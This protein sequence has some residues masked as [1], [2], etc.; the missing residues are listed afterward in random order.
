MSF[1]RLGAAIAVAVAWAPLGAP[2]NNAASAFMASL[3]VSTATGTVPGR[4][5]DR[6]SARAAVLAGNY[7]S[8]LHHQ[9]RERCPS[10]CGDVGADTSDWPVYG[11]LEGLSRAC[12]QTMLLDFALYNLVN[13]PKAKVAISA[14]T[15]DLQLSSS[16]SAAS[17]AGSVTSTCVPEGVQRTKA[18]STLQLLS[19]GNSSPSHLAD[20]TAALDQLRAF[21]SIPDTGCNETIKYAYSGNVAVGIYAGSGL[22]GQDVLTAVLDKLSTKISNDGSVAESLLVQMCSNSSA[23]YTLGVLADTKGNIGSVQ[24]GL[25]SWKNRTCVALDTTAG[26]IEEWQTVSY[27]APSLL[28]TSNSSSANSTS[29]SSITT[30][31][32]NL[33]RW[34]APKLTLEKR[35]DSC[36]TIQVQSGDS[37][38]ALAAECGITPAYSGTLPDFS[39]KPDADG[40]CYSYLVKSGDSCSSIGAAFDLTN[41][42]IASFNNNTWGWNGCEKLFADYKICLS[43]GFPPMPASIPNAVCGP[44]V[45][46]TA[47]PPP[48]TDFSTLNE[49]PLNACC[50]IWGQCGTTNDFCVP[51]NSSTGAPGTAAPGENGCISNCGTD[52]VASAPPDQIMSIAYFEAFSWNRPCLHMSVTSVDTSAYTHIHFSFITLN[53]DFSINTDDVADQLPLFRGMTGIKKIVS[54]GGWTFSTDPSTYTIFRDAVSSQ[55]NRGTLVANVINFLNDYQLDGIDWDWEYPNEPDIPGIPAGS[56]SETTGFFLLLDELKEKMPSGKTVSITAPASFWYLQHFPIQALS[57]VVDYIVYMTYD[58]HGQWDYSNKYADPGC[59]SYSQGLGNCLRSHVNMTETINSLSMITKAGVPSNMVVVGV[60]SYGRSFQMTTPGCWT[61]Q[62]TYTGPDSGAYPGRCTNTSGYISDYEISQILDQN[63][64]AQKLWDEDS[65]SNIVV[66]NDSQWVAYMD[67][68]NKATRK[69]L[70]PSLNFLG[71]ADWAVDLQSDTG[72][73]SESGKDGS[74]DTIYINPDIWASASQQ[75]TGAPG[76]TLIWP[77]MPLESPTT[78]TFPL[79]TTTVSYSSLTTRTS[80]LKDGSTSTYPWYLYISWLTTLTIP[81]VTTTA[82]PLWGVSLDH[83]KTGGPI[84][85]RSSIQPPPFGVTII[86]VTSGTTSIIG[87]TTT[88]TSSGGIIVWGSLTYT[89]PPQTMTLGGTTTII[90]GHV[91]PPTVLTV[92]PNPY[93]TTVPSTIDP[94]INQKTPSWTSGKVPGPTAK[95]GCP[96]CGQ[97]CI[98]FCDPDCPFCPPNVFPGGSGGGGGGGGGD[99]DDPEHSTTSRSTSDHPTSS[100]TVMYNGLY[101]DVFPTAFAAEGDLSSLYSDELSRIYAMWPTTTTQSTDTAGPTDSSTTESATTAGPTESSTTKSTNTAGPTDSSTTESATTAE[102][103]NSSTT[104]R[105]DPTPAA[106]CDFWDEGWGW[107]FEVYNIRDWAA[108]HGSSLHDEESGCGGLTG[109]DWHD[110]TATTWAYAYF[111]LPFFIKDGCVERAIVSAGGPKLSCNDHGLGLR[112]LEEKRDDRNGMMAAAE[113]P[114]FSE[115]EQSEFVSFYAANRT[116]RPYAPMAW[117]TSPASSITTQ[118]STSNP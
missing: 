106:N 65:Y 12:N 20:T 26:R 60:S 82:I 33:K 77:P 46:N 56:E 43:T 16:N 104:K 70:Y 49:C 28:H 1:S 45:N 102:P 3:S 48:G 109:W 31:D 23:R 108:D 30:I 24:R 52:I 116:Y 105:P 85:L 64:S 51:S 90:G 67:E 25:Q 6:A 22:A 100:Y 17:K 66:F 112:G 35:A 21:S 68:D 72:S 117:P 71:T 113:P 9:G 57:L 41:E 32:L 101:D 114:S 91:L 110:T 84:T 94:V 107:T 37:C 19:F 69:A 11:S 76:A 78:I 8:K 58:L 47:T 7:T 89:Q 34:D 40:Y 75:V 55:T 93:P 62:C 2:A 5:T 14:C 97:T 83:N 59:P 44:Q 96:G 10:T 53:K 15:A 74:G 118:A 18:T 36:R 86:P 103:T 54:V 38:A 42:Q 95:P 39:P 79:W 92:T 13:E 63:P 115:Q 61:E 98:L 99:P 81:Q 4:P 27:F 73:D 29:S 111:N 50:N 88:S 80:T 87:A